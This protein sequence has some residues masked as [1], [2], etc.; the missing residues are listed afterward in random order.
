MKFTL[1]ALIAAASMAA[2]QELPTC[3][4]GALKCCREV[5]QYSEL[6]DYVL[7]YYGIDPELNDANACSDGEFCVAF[8]IPRFHYL[9]KLT[10][11]VTIGVDLVDEFDVARCSAN[12]ETLQCCGSFVPTRPPVCNPEHKCAKMLLLILACLNRLR[13]TTSRSTVKM[14]SSTRSEAQ[15]CLPPV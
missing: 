13:K 8:R 10:I 11:S 9:L 2:A 7:E 12:G 6:P 3:A 4:S 14:S 1:V 5:V 15:Q